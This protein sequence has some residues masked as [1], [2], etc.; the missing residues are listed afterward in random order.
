MSW[1]HESKWKEWKPWNH[2]LSLTLEYWLSLFSIN[3]KIYYFKI[4]S[5]GIFNFNP[6]FDIDF[7]ALL[8]QSLWTWGPH[9]TTSIY[10][11]HWLV[12]RNH[13]CSRTRIPVH[14]PWLPGYT[15][16]IQNILIILTMAGLFPDRLCI[17]DIPAPASPGSYMSTTLM[18]S[19]VPVIW[20]NLGKETSGLFP[21]HIDPLGLSSSPH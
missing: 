10:C 3:L 19:Y 6:K 11:P 15:D 21:A 12:Q 16:V 18:P 17:P 14:S 4:Q 2:A 5:I 8:I 20:Y 13:H 1:L 9:R 7:L